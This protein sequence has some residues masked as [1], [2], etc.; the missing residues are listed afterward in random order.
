[1]SDAKLVTAS[2]PQQVGGAVYVGPLSTELPSDAK[3]ALADGFK[4]LGYLSEDGLV[5]SN[6][7]NSETVAAW[8]GDVVL[9]TQKS[10]EDTFKCT[11]IEALNVDVLKTV[12]GGDNVSGTLETGITVKANSTPAAEYAWVFNMILKNGAKKRIVLPRAT[13]AA[14][15]DISYTDSAAVG[16]EV[17]L[18]AALDSSGN[19]HYEYIVGGE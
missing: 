2:S 11:L 8:G 14:L 16:Y 3:T 1:M 10:K 5:N 12:Y 18:N 19:T 7:P 4:A 15:G 9:T 13:L 6:S 17:T